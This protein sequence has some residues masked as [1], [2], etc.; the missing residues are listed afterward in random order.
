MPDNWGLVE[1]TGS[2]GLSPLHGSKYN[3]TCTVKAIDGMHIPPNIEWSIPSKNLNGD[4]TYSKTKTEGTMTTS[5]LSFNPIFIPYGGEYSC[6]ATVFV[7]WMSTQL[8]ALSTSVNVG[9][10]S[11]SI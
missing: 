6:R 7:P 5:T 8:P 4:V 10:K 9:V 11:E 1:I 3:L 2:T